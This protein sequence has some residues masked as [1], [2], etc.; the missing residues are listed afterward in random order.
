M[1][2]REGR[3]HRYKGHAVRKNLASVYG[4]EFSGVGTD[5]WAHM[6]ARAVDD[7]D[8]AHNDLVPYWVYPLPGG[9][10]IERHVYAPPLSRDQE[11]LEAIRRTMAIYRMVVGQPR[12]DDLV[13]YLLE[14]N[15]DVSA[16]D[17]EVLSAELTID[18]AP[19]LK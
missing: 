6:F 12:Q 16:T 2:Q 15:S 5:P 14:Q 17:L 7:R 19:P 9:A 1:E 3:V 18:L 13:Q 8:A 11:R 4:A 10:Q